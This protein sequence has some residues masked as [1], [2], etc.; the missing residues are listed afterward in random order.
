[1][2][3]L[4]KAKAEAK[5]NLKAAVTSGASEAKLNALRALFEDAAAELREAQA[6]PPPQLAAAPPPPQD[7]VKL[8][9]E[10]YRSALQLRQQATR[11]ELERRSSPIPVYHK[12]V[13]GIGKHFPLVGLNRPA[14]RLLKALK[15]MNRNFQHGPALPNYRAT[16]QAL[17][18]VAAPGMGKSTASTALWHEVFKIAQES[19]QLLQG[20]AYDQRLHARITSSLG[21]DNMLVFSM[22]LSREDLKELDRVEQDL[23]MDQ[24]LALRML[25]SAAIKANPRSY[26][27]FL[28]ELGQSI[29]LRQLWPIE[30]LHFIREASGLTA[31]QDCLVVFAFD[32]VNAVPST[33]SEANWVQRMLSRF[34]SMREQ[35][36]AEQQEEAMQEQQPAGRAG[37]LRML[38]LF[39]AASTYAAATS[40]TSTASWQSAVVDLPLQPLSLVDM[41]HIVMNVYQRLQVPEAANPPMEKPGKHVRHV[42]KLVEGNPRLLAWAM[43]AMSNRNTVVDECLAVEDPLACP[44]MMEPDSFD[45]NKLMDT[46]AANMVPKWAPWLTGNKVHIMNQV[47]AHALLSLPVARS[48]SIP[49]DR[50]VTWERLENCGVCFLVHKVYSGSPGSAPSSSGGASDSATHVVEDDEVGVP[51]PDIMTDYMVYVPPAVMVAAIQWMEVGRKS[52]PSVPLFRLVIGEWRSR[53]LTDVSML[54]LKMQFLSEVLHTTEVQL[55]M[56]VPGASEDITL[57]VP[58]KHFKVSSVDKQ[59][60]KGDLQALATK[61]RQGDPWAF[62]G[63][64]NSGPDGWVLLESTDGTPFVLY[65]QS[66]QRQNDE[67]VGRRALQEEAAKCKRLKGSKCYLVYVTDQRP[68]PE[69][70][71]PLCIQDMPAVVVGPD[72]HTSY[73]STSAAH[74][75]QA[76]KFLKRKTPC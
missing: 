63:P 44:W 19:E 46:L 20:D 66:K 36:A 37:L 53:E 74:L 25:Y 33:P 5:A 15:R 61:A 3:A 76:M 72:S 14:H 6:P 52:L 18:L 30:V 26:R 35:V 70:A 71:S 1:M 34:I 58:Q 32:E 69:H 50:D 73:Y 75:V 41:M 9:V 29:D 2:D 59:L 38:P 21:P 8:L 51:K 4:E 7:R 42:L 43:S 39:I 12:G 49:G 47:V 57:K 23:D 17:R 62:V 56:L 64:G 40:L 28:H 68:R 27:Q 13:V 16:D 11:E 60:R 45:I 54:V 48:A 55:E 24:V 67:L 65:V 10:K 31:D 22:D